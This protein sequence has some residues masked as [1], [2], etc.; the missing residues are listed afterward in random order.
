MISEWTDH[1]HVLLIL[2]LNIL[3]DLWLAMADCMMLQII[4]PSPKTDL[5]LNI[6]RFDFAVGIKC[7]GAIFTT[8]TGMFR[9]TKWQT[10]W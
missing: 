9:P 8:K 4:P 10:R 2:P 1:K 7:I 6:N 3:A 5:Q